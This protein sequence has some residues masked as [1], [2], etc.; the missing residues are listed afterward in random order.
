MMSILSQKAEL[1]QIYTP[2]CIRASLISIL[3]RA[4]VQPKQICQITKHKNE[5]SLNWYISDSTSVQKRFCSEVWGNAL[6]VQVYIY[7]DIKTSLAGITYNIFSFSLY[8]RRIL[9]TKATR[10]GFALRFW[11]LPYQFRYVKIVMGLLQ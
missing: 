3:F 4:G 1:S 7:I 2:H 9:D 11:K 8:F 6:P 5:N 10:K